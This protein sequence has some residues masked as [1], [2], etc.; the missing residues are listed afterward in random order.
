M[1][2]KWL[3]KKTLNKPTNKPPNKTKIVD[4]L[5]TVSLI[6]MD[7]TYCQNRHYT[8]RRQLHGIL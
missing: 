4:R 7:G 1:K 6:R 2:I 5:D 3:F 8:I